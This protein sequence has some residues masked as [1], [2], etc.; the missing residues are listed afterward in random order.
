MCT[1]LQDHFQDS[2]PTMINKLLGRLKCGHNCTLN[3]EMLSPN[4]S[5][6]F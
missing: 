2:Y 1:L 4:T 3:F 6:I 5:A